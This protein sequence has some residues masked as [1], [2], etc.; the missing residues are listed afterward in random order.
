MSDHLINVSMDAPAEPGSTIPIAR[1]GEDYKDRRYGTFSILDG[2]ATEWNENIAHLP[3]QRIPV[4]IDHAADRPQPYRSTLAAAW[5]DKVYPPDENGLICGRVAEWTPEGKKLVADGAVKFTSAVFGP[6]TNE[7]GETHPN[8]LS[9]ISLTNKPFITSLPCIQLAS[10]D[11]VQ[12]AI[13][14][15]PTLKALEAALDQGIDIAAALAPADVPAAGPPVDASDA[16]AIAMS[17]QATTPA[18]PVTEPDIVTGNLGSGEIST[19][20]RIQAG[21]AQLEQAMAIAQQVSPTVQLDVDQAERDK[22]HAAGHSLPDKS[23]PITVHAL[24]ESPRELMADPD[25]L[26]AVIRTLSAATGTDY[27]DALTAFANVSDSR[28]VRGAIKRLRGGVNL[29]DAVEGGLKQLD[30]ARGEQVTMLDLQEQLAADV[31]PGGQVLLDRGFDVAAYRHD[32]VAQERD[33][34]RARELSGYYASSPR[35]TFDTDN[36][37]Y[38]DASCSLIQSLERPHKTAQ[39]MQTVA[40]TP[41]AP[42]TGLRLLDQ[43]T[44]APRF[45]DLPLPQMAEATKLWEREG[46]R[47]TLDACA[48]AVTRQLSIGDSPAVPDQPVTADK[49]P[50]VRGDERGDRQELLD[51]LVAYKKVNPHAGYLEAL[52]AV[53]GVT[54]GRGIGQT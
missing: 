7:K 54:V 20:A 23:Y 29:L 47:V 36:M 21:G 9:G 17:T 14:A 38:L 37:L 12:A 27:K 46:R 22:A 3:G 10:E 6:H 33:Y 44:P 39:A 35:E 13:D 16:L 5:V 8:T 51:K 42:D 19:V 52:D 25:A 53:T 4:D 2:D 45:I 49:L 31:G 15:D 30:T 26:N 1:V 48:A 32:A 24:D 43:T 28:T 40:G 11:R 41:P 18:L 50:G 34:R